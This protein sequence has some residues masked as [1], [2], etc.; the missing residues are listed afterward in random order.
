M[1]EVLRLKLTAV[2]R[3]LRIVVVEG[4]NLR[5]HRRCF[6]DPAGLWPRSTGWSLAIV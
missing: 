5:I 1:P 4:W 2:R 3:R 6:A